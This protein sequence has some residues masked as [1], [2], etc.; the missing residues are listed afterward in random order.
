MRTDLVA[1]CL[2]LFPAE[3]V[4]LVDRRRDFE[5]RALALRFIVLPELSDHIF[6]W[7]ISCERFHFWK[8]FAD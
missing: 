6:L 8:K 7:M 3:F 1:R 2:V 4:S 5:V